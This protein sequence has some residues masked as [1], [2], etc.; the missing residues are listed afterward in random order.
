MRF[1]HRLFLFSSL[2]FANVEKVIFL[3]PERLPIPVHHPNID[4]LNLDTIA[5]PRST[6]RTQLLPRFPSEEAKDGSQVWLLVD[7]LLEGTRYEIRICWAATVSLFLSSRLRH[8]DGTTAAD[9]IQ[10]CGVRHG[11]RV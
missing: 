2:A 10:A 7:G 9:S 1:L 3:G 11:Y 6:L 5:P 4:N 8:A